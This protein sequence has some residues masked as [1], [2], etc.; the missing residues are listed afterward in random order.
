MITQFLHFNNSG[1]LVLPFGTDSLGLSPLWLSSFFLKIENEIIKSSLRWETWGKA[2][3]LQFALWWFGR[4]VILGRLFC[5]HDWTPDSL[6][7]LLA[8]TFSVT[9]MAFLPKAIVDLMS[10]T[11]RCWLSILLGAWMIL[12]LTFSCA[13]E[14]GVPLHYVAKMAYSSEFFI[15]SLFY[16]LPINYHLS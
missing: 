13:S 5:I 9:P 10:S 7:A 6:L 4:T 15:W 8:C 3:A 11:L 2:F 16:L 1:Y 14:F 12:D